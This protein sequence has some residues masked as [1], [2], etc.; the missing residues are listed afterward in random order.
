MPW[1]DNRY[2]A[3]HQFAQDIV[4]NVLSHFSQLNSIVD[5]NGFLNRQTATGS[6]IVTFVHQNPRTVRQVVFGACH[7]GLKQAVA[8]GII[9]VTGQQIFVVCAESG[10]HI[11]CK[12]GVRLVNNIIHVANVT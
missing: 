1:I 2:A 5:T 11:L 4:L 3:E 9:E 12:L 8:F 10:K 6:D 7:N